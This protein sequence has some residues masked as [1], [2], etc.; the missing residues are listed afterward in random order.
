MGANRGGKFSS[1][2]NMPLLG[3]NGGTGGSLGRFDDESMFGAYNH[4][5]RDNSRTNS[6]KSDDGSNSDQKTSAKGFDRITM[7]NR[8]LHV[9]NKR[10]DWNNQKHN[11]LKKVFG[12][13]E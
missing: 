1:S 9:L 6:S 8:N 10:I 12:K 7:S 13:G 3:K 2:V 5:T 4:G 11:R